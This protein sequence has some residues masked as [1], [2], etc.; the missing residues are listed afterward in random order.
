MLYR[1]GLTRL[2]YRNPMSRIAKP[3]AMTTN[4]YRHFA[5]ITLIVTV[6]IGAFANGEQREAITKEIAARQERAAAK[7]AEEAGSNRKLK[8]RN[9]E[10]AGSFAADPPRND[11]SA[12]NVSPSPPAPRRKP[13]PRKL[14]K[15]QKQVYIPSGPYPGYVPR[16]AD[17]TLVE[18]FA[19]QNRAQT[20]GPGSLSSNQLERLDAQS[21]R[22][23][24]APEGE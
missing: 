14:P 11:D 18:L 6:C 13:F 21:R 7:E 20:G 2:I 5:V 8:V 23:S 24:G 16:N 15:G 10:S 3:R 9:K 4:V 1:H 12:G 19:A 17:G 22:R